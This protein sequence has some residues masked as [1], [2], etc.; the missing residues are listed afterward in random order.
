MNADVWVLFGCGVIIGILAWTSGYFRGRD[1]ERDIWESRAVALRDAVG[2][3][4]K[5]AEGKVDA[6]TVILICDSWLGLT[7]EEELREK[8]R[9]LRGGWNG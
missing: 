8:A 3:T 4:G 1:G 5:H 7:T 6:E 2:I 9:R